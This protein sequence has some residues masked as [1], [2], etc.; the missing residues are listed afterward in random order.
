[1]N[2]FASPTSPPLS[3][4]SLS[5][6]AA[7][8]QRELKLLKDDIAKLTANTEAAADRIALVLKQARLRSQAASAPTE[9][10]SHESDLSI[11]IRDQTFDAFYEH[12]GSTSLDLSLSGERRHQTSKPEVQ[13]PSFDGESVRSAAEGVF[14]AHKSP[15]LPFLS[16]SK[17][18]HDS[19][20]E[21][22]R[23]FL[24]VITFMKEERSRA[25][26]FEILEVSS[27]VD[28]VIKCHRHTTE[29]NIS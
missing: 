22:S 4:T 2:G 29:I 25:R 16:P 20:Y 26:Q 7:H 18:A 14:A 13:S 9:P 28:A 23:T 17:T 15:T 12:R 27:L 3:P 19:L 11:T 5:V 8:L 21:Q 6:N 1:M 24:S 10:R